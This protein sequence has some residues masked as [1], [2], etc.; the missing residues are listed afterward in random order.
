MALT[1]QWPH[2]GIGAVVVFLLGWLMFGLLP[3]ILLAIIVLVLLGY[4]RIR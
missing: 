4:I 2:V 3:A 1:V